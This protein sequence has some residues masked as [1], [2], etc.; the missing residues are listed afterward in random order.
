MS[1]TKAIP[2][3]DRGTST[4]PK[5]APTVPRTDTRQVLPRQS[6]SVYRQGHSC[7]GSWDEHQPQA[8]PYSP[9][10]RYKMSAP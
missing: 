9:R 3:E 8:C 6:P 10:Y 4:G 7:Q 5:P 1:T 2:A